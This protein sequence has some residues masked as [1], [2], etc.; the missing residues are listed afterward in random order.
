MKYSSFTL[1]FLIFLSSCSFDNK[2]GIW[3]NKEDINE[4]KIDL[5][6]NFE[7]LYTEEKNYDSIIIPNAN[8]RMER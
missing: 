1:L 3:K 6:E 7:K 5:F 8:I 4:K 2:S